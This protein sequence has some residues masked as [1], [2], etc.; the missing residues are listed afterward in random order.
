MTD[1]FRVFLESRASGAEQSGNDKL[2]ISF[3]VFFCIFV[4]VSSTTNFLLLR[5][6]YKYVLPDLGTREVVRDSSSE[7]AESRSCNGDVQIQG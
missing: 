7:T 2:V 5:C 3:D 6:A 1:F 4:L